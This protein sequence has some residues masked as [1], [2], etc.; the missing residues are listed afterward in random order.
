MRPNHTEGSGAA[1]LPSRL[2]V[3][4]T[5]DPALVEVALRL[6]RMLEAGDVRIVDLSELSDARYIN[7]KAGRAEEAA[8]E[9]LRD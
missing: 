3:V 2:D 9:R 8:H 5:T 1:E 7:V 6:V 4:S